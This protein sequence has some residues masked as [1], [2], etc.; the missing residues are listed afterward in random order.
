MNTSA[1]DGGHGDGGHSGDND[2]RSTQRNISMATCDKNFTADHRQFN[3]AIQGGD[4]DHYPLVNIGG[5]TNSNISSSSSNN[6]NNN[7]NNI[8]N[9]LDEDKINSSND[10]DYEDNDTEAMAAVTNECRLLKAENTAKLQSILDSVKNS[11][12]MIFREIGTY[13]HE[14]EE[15]EKTYIQCRANTQ[16]ESRRMECIEPDVIAATTQ[17]E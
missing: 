4:I 8:D 14:T 6:N 7:N 3:D 15:I 1:Y 12:K 5:G 17:R 13:L 9:F 2:D 16:K 10:C 11:T